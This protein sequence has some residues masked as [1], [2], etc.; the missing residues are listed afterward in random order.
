MAQIALN[1]PSGGQLLI[2]PEDG[3]STETVTIPSVGVGKVLQV[4]SLKDNTATNITTSNAWVDVGGT[5]QY[6][7]LKDSSGS[8]VIN[9]A[10]SA[11]ID[12][13][14]LNNAP[15][16][17]LAFNINGGNWVASNDSRQALNAGTN[18]DGIAHTNFLYTI[19]SDDMGAV[20]GDTI[21]IKIQHIQILAD[22]IHYNQS[23][24]GSGGVGVQTH[25]TIMEVAA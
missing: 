12:G 10:L 16:I 2:Q 15:I 14:A 20:K 25:S 24:I 8:L 3:T 9:Y 1:K 19:Y 18:E 13:A 5:T 7:T 17:R 23:S 11:E 22:S 21:G 6:L 4:V